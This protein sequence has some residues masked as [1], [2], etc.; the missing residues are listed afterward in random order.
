MHDNLHGYFAFTTHMDT[1][2]E[3]IGRTEL[4]NHRA[5]CISPRQKMLQRFE[6][7]G[8]QKAVTKPLKSSRR[9]KIRE[10]VPPTKAA[11]PHLGVQGI[12]IERSDVNKVIYSELLNKLTVLK[13]QTRKGKLI[14]QLYTVKVDHSMSHPAKG[15]LSR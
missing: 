5:I 12:L 1:H 10:L 6:K 15:N 4:S 13:E 14:L 9:K 11:V 2:G 8:A 7:I 3:K